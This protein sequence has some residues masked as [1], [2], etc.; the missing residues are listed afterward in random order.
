MLQIRPLAHEID[1]YYYSSSSIA[2]AKIV[3][4]PSNITFVIPRIL[5]NLLED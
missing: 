4:C 1:N 3:F 2:I 5:V